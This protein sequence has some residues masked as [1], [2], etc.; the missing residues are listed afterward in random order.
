MLSSKEHDPKR[1]SVSVLRH[2]KFSAV[3]V[4]RFHCSIQT[5]NHVHFHLVVQ[6]KDDFFETPHL[7]SSNRRLI[8]R[9]TMYAVW[10]CS[11]RPSILA[12]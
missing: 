2:D 7:K 10:S 6:H 12:M 4:I 3:H 9:H 5:C 1:S 11:A 8:M